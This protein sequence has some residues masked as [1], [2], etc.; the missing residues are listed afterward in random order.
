MH[1]VIATPMYGGNC[2][3]AYMES[4]I[5]LTFAL[6]TRGDRI[7]FSRVY[8]ESLITRA[9]NALAYEFLQTDADA[10]LFI[11]ADLAFNPQAV[12]KM[13]DSGKDLI[14]GI[15]PVKDINWPQVQHAAIN[16]ET[17]LV[18]YSG[19]FTANGIP[20]D[21]DIHISKPLQVNQ[22]ATGLMF[23]T[24]TVFEQLAP[25]C[26]T[27][28]DNN[29]KGGVVEGKKVITEFFNTDISEQGVLLSE[30]YYFCDQWRKIG[31]EVY[32]APWINTIHF[33]DYGFSGSFAET[34]LYKSQF[35]QEI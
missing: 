16:G 10:M 31:G 1:I 3:G 12:V 4:V 8:N 35:P 20:T 34:L 14:G 33:G 26:R 32:A 25:N 7:T 13:I 19:V 18:R 22:V 2:K 21:T 30:D 27:Y 17:D 15:Y 5:D 9:R 29:T 24:R 11:D 6:A 28:L 23:I